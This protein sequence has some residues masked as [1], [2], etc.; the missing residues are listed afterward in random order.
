MQNYTVFD[1]MKYLYSELD[2][3]SKRKNS[4]RKYLTLERAVE[5]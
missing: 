3:F 4:E 1:N 5:Y 2:S